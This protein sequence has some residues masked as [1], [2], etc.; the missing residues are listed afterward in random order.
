MTKSFMTD[1]LNSESFMTDG[2]MTESATTKSPMTS[3][4]FPTKE[5]ELI[6]MYILKR[7]DSWIDRLR[8][9]SIYYF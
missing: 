9:I 7:I 6:W 3:P 5:I 2:L 4:R 1:G 8:W